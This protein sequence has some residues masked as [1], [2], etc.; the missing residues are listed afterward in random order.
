[1]EQELTSIVIQ[2]KDS[3]KHSIIWLHGLGADGHDFESLAPS[4]RL[5]MKPHIRFIFPNA[6]IQP[7]TIN[8]G[9]K[10]RAW[11]DILDL[12]QEHHK[13][14]SQGIYQS[15]ELIEGLVRQEIANGISPENIMLAGFSQGGVIALHVGLRFPEK[16]AGILA[17]S[18]YLPTL[19][20][21]NDEGSEAGK[22]TPIFMAHGILD[23]IVA[24][25]AGKSASERLS[26]LGYRVEWHDYLMEHS[27]SSEEVDD[28]SAFINSVFA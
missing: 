27:V 8:R 26:A 25:E 10:M 15:A 21:L 4:L 17:L 14:D 7:V 11:Y 28:I 12:S 19:P 22:S 20:Q 5:A 18:T 9:M 13:V 6:P 23:A 2:P 16:L 24:I 3:H 1:M